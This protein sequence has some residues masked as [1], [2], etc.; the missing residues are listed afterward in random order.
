MGVRPPVFDVHLTFPDGARLDLLATVR[1]PCDTDDGG[2]PPEIPYRLPAAPPPAARDEP[3]ARGRRAR[4]AAPRGSAGR[5][6]V[7]EAYTAAQWQGRDPVLAVMSATG[8]S[9]RRALRLIAAAR[10]DGYL[11]PRHHRR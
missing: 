8:R 2:D 11:N 10:D 7:A 4:P 5:R 9:R 6:A 3:T 1:P